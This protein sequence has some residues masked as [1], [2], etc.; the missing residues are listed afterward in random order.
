MNI[1][2][3]ACIGSTIEASQVRKNCKNFAF[4]KFILPDC[5]D[6]ATLPRP[7]ERD[8]NSRVLKMHR[9]E[10]K[11]RRGKADFMFYFCLFYSV[12]LFSLSKTVIIDILS[13]VG[14]QMCPVTRKPV[15]GVF[16][17]GNTQTGLLR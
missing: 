1:S 9:K 2:G 5:L 15:F 17:P 14:L 6:S 10:E 16:R 11:K 4:R 12:Y 3:P 7:N 13:V 8:P